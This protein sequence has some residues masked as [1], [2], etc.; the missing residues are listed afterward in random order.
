MDK[1]S[2]MF[3]HT[4]G[5]IVEGKIYFF[6]DHP[7]PRIWFK[8]NT[9]IRGIEYQIN[10]SY[11][12][13]KYDD[14]IGFNKD[15]SINRTDGKDI[16]STTYETGRKIQNELDKL[17]LLVEGLPEYDDLVRQAKINFLAETLTSA[18]EQLA[19]LDQTRRQLEQD[20][21]TLIGEIHQLQII[22]QGK[23]CPI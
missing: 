22:Q 16:W 19:S 9:T 21:S 2:F 20:I 4:N 17:P 14:C 23:K 7:H 1:P 5:W 10:Y 11:T 12:R 3:Q 13:P 6:K 18:Q 8:F 15:G